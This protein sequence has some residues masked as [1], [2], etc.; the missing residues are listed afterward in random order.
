MMCRSKRYVFAFALFLLGL[1]QA[2]ATHNRAGEIIYCDLGN[3]LYEVQIITYTQTSSPAD[4]PTLVLDWGDNTLDTLQRTN[5]NGNGVPIP[6]S[7]AQVNTY[8][9][10]HLYRGPGIYILSFVDPNR[11]GGVLNIPR[12]LYKSPFAC[13]VN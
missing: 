11:N 3:L 10:T 12:V 2:F 1:G 7:D 13:K 9:G 8:T 6:G 5:G 4:R